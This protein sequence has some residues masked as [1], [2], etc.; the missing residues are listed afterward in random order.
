MKKTIAFA[1]AAL[2]LVLL[3]AGCAAP[4]SRA[5]TEAMPVT[6]APAED[7]EAAALIGMWRNAGQYSEG[8]DFV[9]TMTLNEDGSCTIHLDYQGEDYQTLSGSYEVKNGVLYTD[10]D[11]ENGQMQRSFQYTLDGR[12]LI[13][14]NEQKSVT[15]IRVD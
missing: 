1:L 7:G 11:T 4:G 3:L 6:E 12:E 13:L 2:T 8:R 9:E 10:L 5:E 14:Q 15:Y